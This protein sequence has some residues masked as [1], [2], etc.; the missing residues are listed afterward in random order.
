MNSIHV[1]CGRLKHYIIKQYTCQT[2]CVKTSREKLMLYSEFISRVKAMVDGA[3]TTGSQA[4]RQ[5]LAA[6]R[7]AGWN[8][9]SRSVEENSRRPQLIN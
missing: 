3:R 6:V 4:V 8:M 9:V 5:M 1:Y 7:S 2:H